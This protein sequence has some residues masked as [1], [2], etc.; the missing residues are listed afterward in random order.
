MANL[1]DAYPGAK[2]GKLT[3]LEVS[4][5][6]VIGKRKGREFLWTKP[7]AQCVCECG[8][9]WEGLIYALGKNTNSCGCV[10]KEMHTTHLSLIH[11]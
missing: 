7:Y 2:F 3:V 4:R 1:A 10:K 9:Q 8:G 11:I 5:A 6:N